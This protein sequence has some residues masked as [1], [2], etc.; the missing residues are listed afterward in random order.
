MLL[1]TYVSEQSKPDSLLLQ[2]KPERIT[3]LYPVLTLRLG[4][5]LFA[6][7]WYVALSGFD[8]ALRTYA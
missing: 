3:S 2:R 1:T 8:L 5:R 7:G 6:Y 4:I